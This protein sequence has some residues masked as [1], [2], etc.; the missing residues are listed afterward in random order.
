MHLAVRQE[1]HQLGLCNQP[2]LAI[3]VVS[4]DRAMK[5]LTFTI[6]LEEIGILDQACIAG[7]L[8]V[9]IVM[10]LLLDL[11]HAVPQMLLKMK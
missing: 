7:G 10:H 5:L 11:L 6:L 2:M 3:L 8:H 1:C 9:A 4:S